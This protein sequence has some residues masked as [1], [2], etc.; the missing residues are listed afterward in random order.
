MKKLLWV[1]LVVGVLVA[2]VLGVGSMLPV[3]HTASVTQEFSGPVGEL[4]L[5]LTNV[6]GYPEWRSGVD[7]VTM[8]ESPSA[9]ASWREDGSDG[10]LTFELVAMVPGE[11]LEVE[12]ADEGLPFGGGWVYELEPSA[13]GVRLTITENGEVYSPLFRFVSRFI[14]GHERTLS[15]FMADLQ[16][17][18][19][20]GVAV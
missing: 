19:G 7:Q 10:T 9:L 18:L 20:G 16:A 2:G 5:A 4:W 14:I 3:E 11:R 15:Q 1:L 12:I 6:E 13:N 17:H 8:I